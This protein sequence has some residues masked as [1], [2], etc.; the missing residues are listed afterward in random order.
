[1]PRP[2]DLSR[3]S[4][5]SGSASVVGVEPVALVADADRQLGHGL[6]R[7]FELHEDVLGRVVPVAVLD[8]VDHRFADGHADPVE[9]VLV[10]A[11]ARARCGR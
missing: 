4:G 1:M 5:A 7:G 11:D 6:R 2:L 10:E 9:G 8:G 3:F